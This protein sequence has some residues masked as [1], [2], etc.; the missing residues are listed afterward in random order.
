M[1][2]KTSTAKFK[3]GMRRNSDQVFQWQGSAP[4]AG[5]LQPA[6]NYPWLS[7]AEGAVPL[8]PDYLPKGK[9]QESFGSD[10]AGS[11]GGSSAQALVARNPLGR[12]EPEASGRMAG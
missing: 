4:V 3:R 9:Q 12:S 2:R 5:G 6:K 11:S 1:I 7:A 10:T 8:P